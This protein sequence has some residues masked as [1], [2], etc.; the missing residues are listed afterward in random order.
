MGKRAM[1]KISISTYTL[2]FYN[3]I[4]DKNVEAKIKQNF[5]NVLRHSPGWES[6]KNVLILL[7]CILNESRK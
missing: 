4:F 3:N 7:N 6:I 1:S 2:F 5:K